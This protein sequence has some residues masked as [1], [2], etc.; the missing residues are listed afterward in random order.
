MSYFDTAGRGGNA[1]RR[2]HPDGCRS[3]RPSGHPP[4]VDQADRH[5]PGHEGADPSRAARAP[6]HEYLPRVR[7]SFPPGR[8]PSSFYDYDQLG[9]GWERP[10]GRDPSLVD[11]R[12]VSS[13][14][15]SRVR[16]RASR[17]GSRQLRPPT[18]SRGAAISRHRVRAR[19]HQ[20]HLK[21]AR[22]QQH[23]G[24]PSRPTTPTPRMSSSPAQDPATIGRDQGPSRGGPGTL[25][26]P[27]A[28]DELLYRRALRQSHV[29]GG[30]AARGVA[31][32][33]SCASFSADQ[34]GHLRPPLQGPSRA[35]APPG[36]ACPTGTG[37]PTASSASGRCRRS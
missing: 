18:A 6:T 29:P 26:K 12:A 2:R 3:P 30:L 7:P 34:Q 11:G 32:A 16:G 28:T 17:P 24:E 20:E 10:A 37:W 27:R 1:L 36:P 15:S 25:D 23:D 21:G 8:R 31:R 19:P 22:H 33:G 5:K 14:R 35:S 4:G 9:S 13:T